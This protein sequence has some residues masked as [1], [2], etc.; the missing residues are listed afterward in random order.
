[1]FRCRDVISPIRLSSPSTESSVT[2]GEHIA[3]MFSDDEAMSLE[4]FS[5]TNSSSEISDLENSKW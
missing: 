2:D 4:G 1:M 3:E 5:S